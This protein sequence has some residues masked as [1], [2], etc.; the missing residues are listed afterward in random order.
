MYNFKYI[1]FIL[2][3]CMACFSGQAKDATNSLLPCLHGLV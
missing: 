2:V 1:Y 3:V